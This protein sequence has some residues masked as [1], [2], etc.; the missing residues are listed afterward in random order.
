MPRLDN[1]VLTE[2]LR[3]RETARCFVCSMTDLFWDQIPD[4]WIDGVF[5]IMAQRQSTIFQVLTKRADRMQAYMTQRD[6]PGR[7]SDLIR[8]QLVDSMAG[9][10]AWPLPNV[11]MGVSTEDQ[12]TFDTR[13]ESLGRTPAATRWISM[14]PMLEEIDPGNAFDDAPHGSEYGPIH[15]IVIGGESGHGARP[16]HLEWGLKILQQCKAAGVSSFFKQAGSKAFIGGL[17]LYLSDRKGEDLSELPPEF[18]IR[19]YPRRIA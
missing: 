11:E 3:W 19:E 15:W 16:F 1:E 18:R 12:D 2:P 9:V 6:L 10:P 5:A 8:L 7:I 14:E 13:V 4:E 17:R